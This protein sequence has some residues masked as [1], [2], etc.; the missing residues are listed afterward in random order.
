MAVN[1]PNV[2]FLMTDQQQAGTLDPGSP[3]QTP[4]LDRLARQ[5]TRF[6]NAHTVNAICSPTRASLFTG[7]YPSQHGM[8]DCAHAVPDYRARLRTYLEMWSQRLAAHGYRCG[9]FGKW[10]VE[11]SENLRHFGFEEYD[12]EGSGASGFAS[13]RRSLGLPPQP[14]DYA[15]RYAAPHRGYPDYLLYGAYDE[16]VEGTRAWYD[17]QHGIDFMQRA[18]A[19]GRP[20]CAFVSHGWPGDPHSVPLSYYERYDPA[21][22]PV[23]PSFH[24]PL[25]DRP[26]LYRRQRALWREMSWEDHARTIACYYARVSL[27]DEQTGR[28]LKALEETGQADNT[29]VVYFNDHGIMMGAHGLHSLGVFPF[30]EGYRIPFIIKWPGQGVAGQLCDKPVNTLDLAPTLLELTGCGPLAQGEGRSLAPLLRGESPAD[31]PDDS[32]AE[33]HGQRYYWTQRLVWAGR[34]KYVFN[35][36]DFD[37]LYDLREDPH[38]MRNLASDPG[39][40]GVLEEMVGRMWAHIRAIGDENMLHSQ[41][42]SLRFAPLGPAA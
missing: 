29:I 31:W 22:I 23:P 30:E 37:E 8:V 1:R 16:P 32:F 36:F 28:I 21:A 6:T 24:D 40:Q 5:G 9:Y 14:Q 27:L 38:E 10:H 20:W 39:H 26:N 11:R 15:V 7:V 19:S 33:F 18:A 41:Y 34:Y 12:L 2:L 3:C 17:Y 42:G 35:A 13:H 25:T 4:N